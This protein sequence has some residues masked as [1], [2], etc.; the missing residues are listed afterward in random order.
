MGMIAELLG[1]VS[2]AVDVLLAL[3]MVVLGAAVLRPVSATAGFAIVAAG[4][5][6]LLFTCCAAGSEP[7][8]NMFGYVEGIS[9]GLRLLSPIQ[10]LIF[11]GL[12]AFAAFTV[13]QE[14]S[15]ATGQGA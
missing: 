7:V 13:A 1:Y 14:K 2:M 15:R 3:V 5:V 9:W 8:M 6:R 12:L 4:G 11:W 10:N